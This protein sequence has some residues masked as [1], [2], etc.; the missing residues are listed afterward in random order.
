MTNA[1]LPPPN[2]DSLPVIAGFNV[3][4]AVGRMLEQPQL[5]L[6]ALQLFVRH[7]A[8]WESNWQALQGD[9][10]AERRHIHALRS[11]AANVGA[12]RLAAAAAVLEE[13]LA[14][15]CVGQNSIV[16]EESR[17]R[18]QDCFR[19]DWQAAADVCQSLQQQNQ[20]AP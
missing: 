11:G 16:L 13:L 19:S 6:E 15:R 2:A 3:E 12:D 14:R 1:P 20:S 8:D 9:D 4:Q 17:S 7:F 10:A 18:V 5:W